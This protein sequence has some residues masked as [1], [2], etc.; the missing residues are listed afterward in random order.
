MQ[1]D[2]IT[3]A[4]LLRG[5]RLVHLI[6]CV[7]VASCNV[8]AARRALRSSTGIIRDHVSEISIRLQ[9]TRMLADAQGGLD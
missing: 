2:P 7:P 1:S 5:E 3:N 8:M 4:R 6:A 9:S